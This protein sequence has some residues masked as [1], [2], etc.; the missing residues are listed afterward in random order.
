MS[1][2]SHKH[3][4]QSLKHVLEVATV[5]SPTKDGFHKPPTRKITNEDGIAVGT[6]DDRISNVEDGR[7]VS[8]GTEAH[9]MLVLR[10]T[11]QE[12]LG[13]VYDSL[14]G[15]HEALPADVFIKFLKEVQGETVTVQP[16]TTQ[17]EFAQFL[18]IWS[19]QYNWDAV[20]P[21]ADEE[22][23]P[24]KP[25]SNYFINSSHNTYLSGNQLTSASSA[26]VY[27]KVGSSP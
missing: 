24:T 12:H 4:L 19:F 9:K 6:I 20:R 2:A 15:S 17:L 3:P 27:R 18:E 5:V 1:F 8:R 10:T 13:R 16:N 7:V 25:I 11:I 22:K 14:R 23:D 21:L 26:E